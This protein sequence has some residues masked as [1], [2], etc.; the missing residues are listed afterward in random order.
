MKINRTVNRLLSGVAV[1]ALT[2]MAFP[3]LAQ[4]D[5]I[6]VT[7]TKRG[8]TALSKTAITANV[9]GATALQQR[10]I[11]NPEDLRFA[12]PGLYV[13]DGS[14]TPRV[15]IRG[16]GFDNF[17]VQAENGVTTYIDGVVVQRTQAVL[18]AFNDVE[19][20]EVL[21]GPQGSAF[22]R[23]STGG[24]V[25]IITQKPQEGYSGQ[26]SAAY[27]SFDRRKIGAIGNYGGEAFGVR[28]SGFYENDDGYITNLVTGSDNLNDLEQLVGRAAIALDPADNFAIDYSFS[29]ANSNRAGPSVAYTNAAAAAN[30]DLIAGGYAFFG[31]PLTSLRAPGLPTSKVADDSYTVIERFDPALERETMIHALTMEWDL[32]PVTLKSITGYVDFEQF[33]R[34]DVAMPSAYGEGIISVPSFVAKSE[35]V[36]QELLLSGDTD[37][38]RWVSGLYYLYEEATDDTFFDFNVQPGPLA[39]PG[40][41][42]S[43]DNGQELNSYAAFADGQFDL[44]DRLRLNAGVRI[45]HDEKEAFGTT[46]FT[47]NG[48]PVTPPTSLDGLSQD[49]TKPSWQAGLE[50]DLTDDVFTFAKVSRGIKA[51]GVNNN[52]GTTYDPE[53]LDA[54]EAGFK[55]TFFENALSVAASG[56]YNSYKD[57]QVFVSPAGPVPTILN[58][59]KASI[60][61]LDFEATIQLPEGLSFDAGLTWLPRARYDDFDAV[62]PFGAATAISLEG[63]RL[64]RSPEF[65]GVFGVNYQR[66]ISTNWSVSG[67]A[68]VYV[69]SDIAFSPFELIRPD[70]VTQEGYSIA[71]VNLSLSYDERVDFRFY[72]KNLGDEFYLTTIVESAGSQFAEFGRPREFG[73]EITLRF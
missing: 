20:I 72:G 26:V 1:S 13:D 73:G 2:M 24:S 70:V 39:P 50:F 30:P 6:V 5:E 34:S 68:D 35:Q 58:A 9:L 53:T 37:R 43:I 33:Y 25:N 57:S 51:G 55:G 64:S 69:T 18:G 31:F 28:L 59:P 27:G 15:A 4:I 10:E 38:F 66:E 29:Y 3:A 41:G 12:V 65:T 23:N 19:R 44:T 62:D 46:V 54:Y 36:S 16:V 61:G 63:A 56:F 71:N 32:G 49:S 60:A 47:F 48:V 11:R 7:A 40:A 45:T 42:Q 52:D 17:Q 22:G 21:K 14:S 8:E 67:R